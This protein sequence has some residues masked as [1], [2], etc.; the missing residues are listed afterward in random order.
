LLPSRPELGIAVG[1]QKLKIVGTDGFLVGLD[2]FFIVNNS[3]PGNFLGVFTAV[4][5]YKNL[6]YLTVKA[7]GRNHFTVLGMLNTS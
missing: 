1:N 3:G 6:G 5:S 4:K 2:D 7:F